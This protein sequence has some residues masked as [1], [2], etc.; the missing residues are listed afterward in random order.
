M[1]VED[2]EDVRRLAVADLD[3]ERI[4]QHQPGDPVAGPHR[5]LR[6]QPAAE[7][8]ADQRHLRCGQ[9]F[10]E[11]GVEIQQVVD[12]LEIL[13]PRG[14]AEAGMGGG[15]HRRPAAQQFEEPRPRLR[16]LEAMQEYQGRPLATAQ[17]LEV[18]AV[19]AHSSGTRHDGL[20]PRSQD[21]RGRSLSR[22]SRPSSIA[23]MLSTAKQV[24]TAAALL[25]LPP[26]GTTRS[27]ATSGPKLVMMRP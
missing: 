2:V 16:L 5:Q 10:E 15:E 21:Y 13:R 4:H 7:G 22:V 8:G 17:Q 25:K 18:D 3:A 9:R 24:M 1:G 27:P 19:H 12:T 23:R 11:G 14:A 20:V 26:K 6:R